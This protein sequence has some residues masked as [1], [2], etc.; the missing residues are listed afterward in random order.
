MRRHITLW[1]TLCLVL[2]A[3]T[4]LAATRTVGPG[5]T[6][7]KPCEA[8]AA[9][10]PGDVIEVDASGSYAGDHCSWSTDNLTVRG[11]GGRAKIDG[12]KNPANIAAGKGIF[13]ITAPNATVENFELAGA[14]T[15]SDGNGAGI[16][17]QGVNLT[18][19]NC[20]FHDNED[21]ILGG[22]IPDNTGEV[23]IEASEFANNGIGD[24]YSHNMYLNHYAKFTLRHS[25]THGANV[26][27]LIKS[28]ALEN[29]ILYNR[30]TGEAGSTDSYE[31]NLPNGGLSFVIGNLI[32]QPATTQNPAIIDYASEGASNPD[33]HL[34]VVNNTVVNDKGSG[35][36]VQN[37]VE[38]P[39]SIINNIFVGGGKVT[40][41]TNAVLTT[42]FTSDMGDPKLASPST[43][44][45]HL[46]AGSPCI[47]KGTDP[48]M[49]AGQSLVPELEYE[50][51]L[52]AKARTSVGTIDIG[53]YEFG[54]PGLP[55]DGGTNQGPTDD[56]GS[57]SNPGE[58][59][60]DGGTMNGAAPI[61][62]ETDSGCGCHV[63]AQ[64]NVLGSVGAFIALGLLAMRRAKRRP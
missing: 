9:A 61:E 47:D 17:H 46:L 56:G 4:A 12:G 10:E 16:R 18:V 22:P 58:S 49:G 52:L 51:P 32:E 6:Y 1:V 33:H 3:E 2:P 11:V 31:I 60:Q 14:A 59:G 55:A 48:G 21:G 26:G 15:A 27:H 8:I 63:H 24:G 37:P 20:F 5:K 34:F 62:A 25:Y 45:Y 40:S 23:L 7:A 39:A 50:H 13:A 64:R 29:H 44:D 42:N 36:F 43:Y 35:T 19:R 28:R 30:I 54:N 38:E 53:A 57:S 41:Q